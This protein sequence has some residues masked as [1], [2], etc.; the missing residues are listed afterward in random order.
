MQRGGQLHRAKGQGAATT[1]A[2]GGRRRQAAVAAAKRA[3]CGREHAIRRI[4]SLTR[5]PYT[6]AATLSSRQSAPVALAR[7]GACPAALTAMG[8]EAPAISCGDLPAPASV[9]SA[10]RDGRS[11]GG[12]RRAPSG[13]AA[14]HAT[15]K[16]I[17]N[18]TRWGVRPASLMVTWL[19]TT[20]PPAATPPQ[21]TALLN[22]HVLPE[23]PAAAW[24]SFL[25]PCQ[26]F[27][28]KSFTPA[29]AP[30]R[31]HRRRRR[32]AAR[33]RRR[34]RRHP[35]PPLPAALPP[36]LQLQAPPP[37]PLQ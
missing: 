23:Q 12:G 2:A 15:C 26:Q 7:A 18:A 21:P 24:S 32:P 4:G 3:S 33:P 8:R 11:Q 9:S 20:L 10:G 19:L 14:R 31:P 5:T 22:L 28:K 34:R 17:P 37:S 13:A 35:L 36:S 30:R 16:V 1:S 6:T 27:I 29:W 25:A